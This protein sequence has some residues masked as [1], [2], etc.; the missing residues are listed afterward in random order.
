MRN[1]GSL[2]VCDLGVLPSCSEDFSFSCFDFYLLG[3][4]RKNLAE[5]L[6]S[7]QVIPT[8]ERMSL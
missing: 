5:L 8:T 7:K 4:I 3:E 6:A 1:C 2:K